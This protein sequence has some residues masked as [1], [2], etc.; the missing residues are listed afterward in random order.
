MLL[1]RYLLKSW[2]R[3]DVTDNEVT[4]WGVILILS[5]L[6]SYQLMYMKK[7]YFFLKPII[8]KNTE[9]MEY[10]FDVAVIYRNQPHDNQW[11]FKKDIIFHSATL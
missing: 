2:E 9:F 11:Y 10:L 4:D 7:K 5:H 1:E 3:I 8:C 6:K